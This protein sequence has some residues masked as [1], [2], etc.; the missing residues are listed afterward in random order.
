[1]SEHRTIEQQCAPGDHVYTMGTD[2]FSAC[3]FCGY[4]AGDSVT[5]NLVAELREGGRSGIASADRGRQRRAADEIERLTAE[6]DLNDW[7]APAFQERMAALTAERDRLLSE[8][9]AIGEQLDR[10]R[11]ERYR[12]RAALERIANHRTTG[13]NPDVFPVKR[14][15][16]EALAGAAT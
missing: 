8:K 13:A 2:G 16:E 7:W 12:L 3:V 1:M 4:R 15:A 5:S 10:V 6:R 14:I 9:Y 11:N